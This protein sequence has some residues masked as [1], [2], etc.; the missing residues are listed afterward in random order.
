VSRYD[1]NSDGLP[2]FAES[3]EVGE[4]PFGLNFVPPVK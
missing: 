1:L 3:I 4:N 2:I